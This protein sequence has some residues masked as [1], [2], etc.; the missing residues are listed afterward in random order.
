[1]YQK[2]QN[3][4]TESGIWNGAR[5]N[6]HSFLLSPSVYSISK[7][8]S[9]K[10]TTLG[11]VLYE[12]MTG[13]SQMAIIAYDKQANYRGAW[14]QIRK[15]FSTGVPVRYHELQGMNLRD[16]PKLLK[17]DLMVDENGDFKI[18]EID[19]HNKHGLGYSTLGKRLREAVMPEAKAYPGVVSCLANEIRRIGHES[20]TFLYADQERFYIPEFEIA[21]DE[22]KQNGI[23]ASLVSEMDVSDK[24][25]LQ[26]LFLDLPFMYH[27]DNL[28]DRLV[29]GYKNGSVSFV[30]PP[31]P[32]L[33]AKG[34]LALLRNDANDPHLESILRAFIRTS[35]LDFVRAWLP[36]THLVGKLGISEKRVLEMAKIKRYV[37]KES[38][39][40]G[41]K[42][43]VFSDSSDF[44]TTLRE[45]SATSLNWILQE[46]VRNQS[47]KFSHYENGNVC[48]GEDWYMRVTVQYINRALGD[49]IV[50]ARRDK[51]V[52]GAKDCIQIGAILA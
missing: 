12:C 30:L 23:H 20:I 40:S 45:A 31:K 46:E 16:L 6:S 37:L 15:V 3:V 47:Q 11:Q 50:T 51:A 25:E 52:H 42:G 48:S 33:G 49:V 29:T 43:T 21:V 41:M 5:R 35:S 1:M 18:A 9:E 19:G 10:V 26:G 13:L 2:L 34:V 36:E 32:F 24:D 39:S 17:L 4:I 44:E 27:N 7:T 22:L 8:Q 38:I 28:T 14:P